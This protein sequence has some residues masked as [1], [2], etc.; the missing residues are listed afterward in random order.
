MFKPTVATSDATISNIGK[1]GIE[2]WRRDPIDSETFQLG[3]DTGDAETDCQN[4]ELSP[5][6]NGSSLQS[7]VAAPGGPPG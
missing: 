6:H 4:D 7:V 2:Q 5:M 3:F 1:D